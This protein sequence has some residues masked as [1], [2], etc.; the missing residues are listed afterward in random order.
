MNI[1]KLAAVV[2]V[3]FS[4]PAYAADLPSKQPSPAVSVTTPFS[5]SGFYV[6]AQAGYLWGSLTSVSVAAPLAPG[7]VKTSLNPNGVFGGGF[8]GYNWQFHQNLVAGIETDFNGVGAST[9]VNPAAFAQL[10]ANLDWFGSTRLRVGYASDRFMPFLTAGVAYSGYEESAQA[11]GLG[12]L[13]VT[14]KNRVS[15]VGWTIGLGVEY[16]LTDHFIARI[17]YRYANYGEKSISVPTPFRFQPVRLDLS[18]NDVRLGA[19]YKF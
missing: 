19:S 13:P 3:T 11:F 15:T 18:T 16:A 2:L 7:F 17:E 12:F 6:G 1:R 4:C 5:W 14:S 8:A 9:T 10:K